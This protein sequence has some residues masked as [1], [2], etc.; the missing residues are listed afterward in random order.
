M[1]FASLFCNIWRP[2]SPEML[3]VRLWEE[4]DSQL[5]KLQKG[6]EIEVMVEAFSFLWRYEDPKLIQVCTIWSKF[7]RFDLLMIWDVGNVFGSCHN[8][9]TNVGRGAAKFVLVPQLLMQKVWSGGKERV[10]MQSMHVRCC[11]TW[12][13]VGFHLEFSLSNHRILL[14]TCTTQVLLES[15][16]MRCLC[17][18]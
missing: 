3:A 13:T 16:K 2:D 18:I 11:K 9:L 4:V 10:S 12:K 5:S 6:E 8:T 17:Q 14:Q 1:C 15:C 7:A